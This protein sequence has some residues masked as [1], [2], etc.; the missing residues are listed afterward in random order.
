[1]GALFRQRADDLLLVVALNAHAKTATRTTL[2]F[3][4][5]AGG[6]GG[7]LTTYPYKLCQKKCTSLATTHMPERVFEACEKQRSAEL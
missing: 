2:A 1:V 5:S 3:Q 6:G 7:A 4:P